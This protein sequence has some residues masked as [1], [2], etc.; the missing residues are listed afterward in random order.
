MI[1]FWIIGGLLIFLSKN[2]ILMLIGMEIMN[3][4]LAY[5]VIMTKNNYMK[6]FGIFKY[7]FIQSFLMYIIL[8]ILFMFSNK[9]IGSI[10]LLILMLSKMNLFPGHLWIMEIFYSLELKEF[11]ILGVL[12]KIPVMLFM[13]SFYK[14]NY[15]IMMSVLI[16]FVWTM[17]SMKKFNHINMLFSFSNLNSSCW[18]VCLCLAPTYVFIIFLVLY[19]NMMMSLIYNKYYVKSKMNMLPMSILNMAG[20]PLGSMFFFKLILLNFIYTG[21]LFI[22]LI[23]LINGYMTYMYFN[24]MLFLMKSIKKNYNFKVSS[25]FL[26][27][28]VMTIVY[29]FFI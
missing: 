29:F 14:M 20:F 10:F 3:L 1:L 24:Y 25:F 16:T 15:I 5:K 4:S 7:Y 19:F 17:F 13:L 28:M 2:M 9:F 8:I 27:Y 23:L 12:A 6:F 26:I 22:L 21:N 11:F 18:M